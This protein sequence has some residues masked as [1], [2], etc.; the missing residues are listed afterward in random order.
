MP[1]KFLKWSALVALLA[2]VDPLPAGAGDV[3]LNTGGIRGPRT[4][5]TL[6]E[7]RRAM[8]VP[9]RWDNSC[10]SAALSTILTYHYNDK[11][12]EALI[13]TSILRVADPVKIRTRGGFSLLDLKRFVESRGYEGKGY[14]GLS[15]E[16][17]EGF[18]TPA[19]V[20][21]HVKGYDH[22]VV[23]RGIRGNRVVLSDPAFGT[24]TLKVEQFLEVWKG[25]IGFV[26]LRPGSTASYRGLVP[27]PEELLVPDLDSV[28]RTA[29]ELRPTAFTRRGP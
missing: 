13:I 18:K 10:G 9:Q 25:G 12:S 4:I 24:L 1:G 2:L 27:R 14:A 17:L 29:L 7:I 21:V 28:G 26:V 22:F 16:D 6:V 3:Y 8:T 20:P 23:F 15:L 19:I 5:R 11:V